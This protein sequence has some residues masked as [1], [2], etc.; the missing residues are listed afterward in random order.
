MNSKPLLLLA[1]LLFLP[2]VAAETFYE[3]FESFATLGIDPEEPNRNWYTY[4]D[5]TNIGNVTTTAP[6]LQGSKSLRVVSAATDDVSNK[7]AEFNLVTSNQLTNITFLIEG[8][9]LTDSTNGSL[10]VIS[11]DSSFPT[12]HLVQ[13]FLF[14]RND[15][16]NSSYNDA[17]QLRVRTNETESDGTVLVPYTTNDQRFNITVL[18]DW[19]N[20]EFR[21]YVDGVNDGVFP[22]YEIPHDFDSIVIQQYRKDIPLNV[23]FDAYWLDGAAPV[24]NNTVDGDIAQGIQDFA[25]DM[26]F[27]TS[28]SLFVFGL[29]LFIVLNAGLLT[30]MF[31]HGKTNAIAPAAALFA[32]F[33][34]YWL[35]QMRFWP[36]WF[37]I[38]FII[39]VSSMVGLILRRVMLGVKDANQGPSLVVGS[40]GFFIICA[41]FL[42]MA[43]YQVAAI[44]V[45]TGTVEETGATSQ[46]FGEATLECV[47]TLFTDC[48]EQSES[49]LWKTITDIFGWII[50]SVQ[51]L[52]Q[53]MTFQLPIPVVLNIIIVLPPAASL[54]AYAIQLVRG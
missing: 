32:L 38:A 14:C 22:F 48:S 5:I 49:A 45:P 25:A 3:D 35:I 21:L 53:L 2:G 46:S 44:E 24:G 16:G 15:T 52:F 30:A 41:T 31:S 23:T 12:R 50:A 26:H 34:I 11:L 33:V 40:L 7:F 51:Y 10:Q 9:T 18:P 43:G 37:S 20:A 17:C 8:S 42:A 6:I 36:D 1:C 39:Y 4:R 47:V 29:L 28:T 19:I 54:G 27:T 13:F